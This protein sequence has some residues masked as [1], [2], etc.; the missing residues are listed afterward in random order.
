MCRERMLKGHR[1]MKTELQH[2]CNPYLSLSDALVRSTGLC[3]E[4]GYLHDRRKQSG[5]HGTWDIAEFTEI[6]RISFAQQTGMAGHDAGRV[7][8][9][10]IRRARTNPAILICSVEM[11]PF[12]EKMSWMSE[13]YRKNDPTRLVHYEGLSMTAATMPP[14]TWKARC[15]LP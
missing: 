12:G 11:H 15:I 4:Y 13:F 2:K 7:N 8:T 1:D 6:T 9:N 3:D 5:V 14:V 10:V